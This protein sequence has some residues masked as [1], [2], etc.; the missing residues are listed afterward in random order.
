MARPR[1]VPEG[2]AGRAADLAGAA[3]LLAFVFALSSNVTCAGCVVRLRNAP[4]PC[5]TDVIWR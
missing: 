4:G 3:L 1:A 2:G 5:M